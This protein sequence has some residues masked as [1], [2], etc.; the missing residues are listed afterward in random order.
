MVDF[1][2]D[3]WLY[4]LIAAVLAIISIL[5]PW[6]T[7]EMAGETLTSWMGGTVMSS[8]GDIP[9]AG[10]S[11]GWN[12]AGLSLWTLGLVVASIAALLIYGVN[13]W[14]GN[15]FKWDWLIYAV[16]GIILF[17]F[18]ILTLIMEGTSGAVI[19]FAPIGLIIAGIIAIGAFVVDKFLGKE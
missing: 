12:G 3:A 16:T 6:G 7:L 8:T 18:P 14:R 19:G 13:S 10:I 5:T 9:L 2:K 15:E 11:E 4:A 17:I 1:K